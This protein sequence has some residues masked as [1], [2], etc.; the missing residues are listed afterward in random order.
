MQNE[1][2][3]MSDH[4]TMGGVLQEKYEQET[5]EMSLRK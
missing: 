5:W 2:N 3:K 1:E 4:S